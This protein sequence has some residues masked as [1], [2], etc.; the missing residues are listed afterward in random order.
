VRVSIKLVGTVLGI[1]IFDSLNVSSLA[2]TSYLV[3]LPKARKLVQSY[4]A[5][6]VLLYFGIGL[7][8][9]LALHQFVGSLTTPKIPHAMAGLIGAS[10]VL[11]FFPEPGKP[12][13]HPKRPEVMSPK[14]AFGLG[15]LMTI[16]DLSTALPYFGA[17]A[18][19]ARSDESIVTVLSL[20][21]LYN[22]V[23]VLPCVAI[24]LFAR[25]QGPGHFH[26]LWDWLRGF[27]RPS[28]R[29]IRLIRRFLV[30]LGVALICD[31]VG[32]FITGKSLLGF[33]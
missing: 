22:A 26:R 10:L 17:L 33:E 19:I 21:G 14:R 12:K 16:F 4:L 32:Y 20:L 28:V 30:G 6:I 13:T 24:A 31:S 23:F 29:S 7:L 27:P 1:A 15:L 11:R 3:T 25:H 8:V 9:V 2:M 5:A 18:V